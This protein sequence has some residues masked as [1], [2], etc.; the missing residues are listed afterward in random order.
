VHQLQHKQKYLRQPH[1]NKEKSTH[2]QNHKPIM[3]LATARY[4]HKKEPEEIA[5]EEQN[6]SFLRH[7]TLTFD[8]GQSG[9]NK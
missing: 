2:Q 3:C 4:Q 5:I 8:D 6:S 7:T 1:Q 9:R